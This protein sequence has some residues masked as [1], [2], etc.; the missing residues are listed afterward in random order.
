[1]VLPRILKLLLPMLAA[2]SSLG[3]VIER[4]VVICAPSS[5]ELMS[6]VGEKSED[7]DKIAAAYNGYRRAL[8]DVVTSSSA[9]HAASND[10]DLMKLGSVEAEELF[11]PLSISYLQSAFRDEFG[12]LGPGVVKLSGKP[13]SVERGFPLVNTRQ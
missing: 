6:P 2:R 3:P 7:L 10:S 13:F 11:T 9:V 8:L 1:M 5:G 12:V 4:R